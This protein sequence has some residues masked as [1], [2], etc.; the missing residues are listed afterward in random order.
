MAFSITN[1]LKDHFS[2]LE[3]FFSTYIFTYIFTCLYEY[4]PNVRVLWAWLWE[5]FIWSP[6]PIYLFNMFKHVFFVLKPQFS[7]CMV[8]KTEFDNELN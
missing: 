1:Y 4:K 5:S 7:V 3:H 2:N 8:R 6:Y